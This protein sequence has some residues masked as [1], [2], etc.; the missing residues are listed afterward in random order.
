MFFWQYGHLLLLV[1]LTNVV[2]LSQAPILNVIV[3]LLVVW[4]G[5]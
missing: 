1:C 4:F 5:F 2:S 3:Y